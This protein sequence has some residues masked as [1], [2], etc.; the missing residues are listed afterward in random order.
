MDEHYLVEAEEGALTVPS[1]LEDAERKEK[2][3]LFTS[4]QLLFGVQVKYTLEI[5]NGYS[6]TTLPLVPSCIR[7]II[8]LRGQIIPIIDVRS[9]LGGEKT[10]NDCI[11]T[12]N[13]EDNI[14]GL[15]VDSVERIIE[16]D[17]A[18]ILPSPSKT[19]NGLVSGMC[20]LSDE[21][22]ML[23]LDCAQLLRQP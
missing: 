1:E 4:N 20:S 14:L 5:I 7:G 11:V 12:L 10:E 22:T 19:L 18:T 6:F 21:Q 15:L 8:N 3:L 9:M 16:L 13:I 17:P 23:L 2:Y